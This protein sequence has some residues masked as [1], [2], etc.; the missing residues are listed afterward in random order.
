MPRRIGERKISPKICGGS[1]QC[2]C[3]FVHLYK[4]ATELRERLGRVCS[5]TIW[6]NGKSGSREGVWWRLIETERYPPRTLAV[7]N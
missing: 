2:Q 4:V 6:W 7:L 5:L 1:C 3:E